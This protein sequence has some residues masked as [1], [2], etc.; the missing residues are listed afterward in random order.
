MKLNSIKNERKY[1]KIAKKLKNY[2]SVSCTVEIDI[3]H[4][5]DEAK[6]N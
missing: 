3:Y 5:L 2:Y 1:T 6:N 4:L